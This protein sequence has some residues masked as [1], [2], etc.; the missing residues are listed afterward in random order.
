VVGEGGRGEGDVVELLGWEPGLRRRSPTGEVRVF[1][2]GL[3]GV[4]WYWRGGS[5]EGRF[6][7]GRRRE[8]ERLL[9]RSMS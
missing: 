4:C 1:A 5:F 3:V 2:R 6:E 8:P 9:A 7:R